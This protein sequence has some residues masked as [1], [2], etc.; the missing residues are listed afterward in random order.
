VRDFKM[1]RFFVSQQLFIVIYGSYPVS[2]KT[3]DSFR[4]IELA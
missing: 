4:F 1:L 3:P 2:T